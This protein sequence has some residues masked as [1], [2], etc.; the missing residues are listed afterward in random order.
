MS[1]PSKH[2]NKSVHVICGDKREVYGVLSCI[3]SPFS[4]ILQH[5]VATNPSPLE[6]DIEFHYNPQF[7][8]KYFT[9]DESLRDAY[10]NY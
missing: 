8:A 9:N 5:A 2:L 10:S 7:P 3:S 1:D 4:I 6:L